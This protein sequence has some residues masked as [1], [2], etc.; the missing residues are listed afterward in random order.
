MWD[1]PLF[2]LPVWAF[3]S[4]ISSHGAA[5]I[6]LGRKVAC[7]GTH[8]YSP[9]LLPVPCEHQQ[10]LQPFYAACAAKAHSPGETRARLDALAGQHIEALRKMVKRVQVLLRGT[11]G[12]LARVSLNCRGHVDTSPCP[13]AP[14]LAVMR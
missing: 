9:G 1:R 5:P 8:H 10:D 11:W 4:P 3:S 6:K 12:A 7:D 14:A 13:A 2:E